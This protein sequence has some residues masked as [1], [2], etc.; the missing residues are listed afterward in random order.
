MWPRR[1]AVD[2]EGHEYRS[3]EIPVALLR[4]HALLTWEARQGALQPVQT[5]TPVEEFEVGPIRKR[6]A[7]GGNT[8]Q[9]RFRE[10]ETLLY[11][12]LSGAG[13]AGGPGGGIVVARLVRS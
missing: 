6:F 1:D 13:G 7:E 2:S 8:G 12:L 4:A 10:V 3:N 9:K 11:R 5:G